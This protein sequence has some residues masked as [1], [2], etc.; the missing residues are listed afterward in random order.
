MHLAE[1]QTKS[2]TTQL[3]RDADDVLDYAAFHC[4][5]RRGPDNTQHTCPR[6]DMSATSSMASS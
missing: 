2:T 3:F 1:E 5:R 6:T 4:N